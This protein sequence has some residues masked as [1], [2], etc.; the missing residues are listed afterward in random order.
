MYRPPTEPSH[1]RIVVHD[2]KLHV[3]IFDDDCP[4]CRTG[5][6]RLRKRDTDNKVHFMPLSEAGDSEDEKLPP[7][8][9]LRK[10]IHFLDAGGEVYKGVDAIAE[11]YRVTAGG[12]FVAALLRL[13]VV[14]TLARFV[15][16]R[17][18]ENRLKLSRAMGLKGHVHQR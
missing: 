3:L 16:R 1:R 14:H 4:I 10:E 6:K 7:E 2:V 8:S 15:Y 12:R 17:V 13:P 5:V 9:E 11:F 18:A